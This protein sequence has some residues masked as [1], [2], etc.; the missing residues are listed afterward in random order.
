MGIQR[1]KAGRR[2]F[3]QGQCPFDPGLV[4][5]ATGAEGISLHICFLEENNVFV[6]NSNSISFFFVVIFKPF[7]DSDFC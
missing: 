7:T 3:L 4:Q 1:G 2:Q 5:D 6:L